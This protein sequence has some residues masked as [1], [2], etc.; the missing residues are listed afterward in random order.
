MATVLGFVPYAHVADVNVSV[1]F[2][3]LFGMSLHSR[4]GPEGA[5]FWARMKGEHSDLM[6]ASATEPIDPRVQAVLFYLHVDD[7]SSLRAHL[8]ASGVADGGPY[9]GATEGEFPRSGLLFE[10][11]N[12]FYMPEG[13]MR[14]HDPDG[15]VLLVGQLPS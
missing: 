2:Y 8:L 5:P 7:L 3:K 1:E 4:F 13:E 6:L 12:P 15:Y 10:I 14:V 11:T 9:K